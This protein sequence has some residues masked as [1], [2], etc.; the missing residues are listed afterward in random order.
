MDLC[1]RNRYH[2][3]QQQLAAGVIEKLRRKYG[4]YVIP[5]LYKNRFIAR[6]EPEK[7]N[8]HF[9]IKNWWWEK[10]IEV[11]NDLIDCAM[12]AAKRFSAY[13]KTKEGVHESVYQTI[14]RGC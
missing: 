10:D 9:S 12:Q 11:S 6:F 4:Y 7:S 3:V 2:L 1:Y 13:L 8:T 14:K 5:V